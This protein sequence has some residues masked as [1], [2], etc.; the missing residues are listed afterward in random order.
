MFGWFRKRHEQPSAL[1]QPVALELRAG[2]D[3]MVGFLQADPMADDDAIFRHL[4]ENGLSEQQATKLIQFTPIAFTR[5][6]YRDKG[7]RFAPNYVV[8]GGDGQP[9]A[10]RLIADEPAYREAW[11]HCEQATSGA[12]TENYFVVVAAR[13]G[14]Y[15]AIQDLVRQGSDLASVATG[16][17]VLME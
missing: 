11:S 1:A 9:V 16:P 5:F 7:V 2:V 17:P 3:A 12:A 13:S 4:I 14:G 10:Q 15:R 6:L 8:L